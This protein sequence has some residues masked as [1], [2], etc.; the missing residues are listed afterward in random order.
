MFV[1]EWGPAMKGVVESERFNTIQDLV[2][3][4]DQLNDYGDWVVMLN[5]EAAYGSDI[6]ELVAELVEQLQE[7]E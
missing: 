5:G 2:D 6:P 7:E 4:A 3:C 1:L